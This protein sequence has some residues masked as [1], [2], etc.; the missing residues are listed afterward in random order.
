MCR[1]LGCWSYPNAD[2][3]LLG[4]VRFLLRQATGSSD[5]TP[6]PFMSLLSVRY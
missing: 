1:L 4:E 5:H 6:H 3:H 2:V